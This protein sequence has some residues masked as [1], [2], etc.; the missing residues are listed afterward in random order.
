MASL[1][2]RP[3]VP[4]EYCA[5]LGTVGD[6]IFADFSQYAAIEKGGIQ[7][8]VSMHVQFTTAEMAYRFLYRFDGM[9]TWDS[10][11][12]P[13]KGTNTLSPFVALATRS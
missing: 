9:P 4:V 6:I 2:G 13:Y 11:L 10:A 12:T 5:T 8:A 1:L 7:T 3:V